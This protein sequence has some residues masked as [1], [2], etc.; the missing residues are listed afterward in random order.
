MNYKDEEPNRL[1]QSSEKDD[2][3]LYYIHF[4]AAHKDKILY[5]EWTGE[6]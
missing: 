4:N 6:H 3:C 5:N 1:K 2:V